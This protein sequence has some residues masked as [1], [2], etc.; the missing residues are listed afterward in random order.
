M[1]ARVIWLL[2]LA[3]CPAEPPAPVPGR[4]SRAAEPSPETTPRAATPAPDAAAFE[5]VYAE[6][7]Q[8]VAAAVE[9]E[10]DGTDPA[11]IG[12]YE[13][14]LATLR[15][16]TPSAHMSLISDTLA[17]HGIASRDLAD[18]MQA[19]RDD[20]DGLTQEMEARLA[21]RQGQVRAVMQ[22]VAEL[23]PPDDRARI[24]AQLAAL[25]DAGAPSDASARAADW[26]S[27]TTFEELREVADGAGAAKGVVI[28]VWAQWCMPCK[29]LDKTAFVDPAV[30]AELR[31]FELVK[32]DV[33]ESGPDSETILARLGAQSL[34]NVLVFG[35][36][37]A[38]AEQL[39]APKPVE[40]DARV[41]AAI[42]GAELAR[43]LG[44][45]R[46]SG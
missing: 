12:T 42:E 27:V 43:I 28:D 13:D 4:A 14:G 23:A 38:L 10:L 36:G 15:R 16:V 33:T 11:A 3:A 24:E 7:L 20:A 40:P 41:T 37:E 17:K 22:R 46:T 25:D 34:P 31:R 5:A 29:E 21:K 9:K 2:G 45:V 19:H 32:I 26:A 18:W 39:A 30:V 35:S 8:A 44:G 6:A 1:R